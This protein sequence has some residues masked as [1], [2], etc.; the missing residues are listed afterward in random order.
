MFFEKN[1][2]MFSF[3]KKKKK[4]VIT[5]DCKTDKILINNKEI[6][7]PTNHQDL[8]SILGE[9]T[10]IT[11]NTDKTYIFW[12]DLGIFCGYVNPEKII[13]ISFLQKIKSVTNY[14]PKKPF[15]GNLFFNNEDITNEEFIKI[16]FGKY[17][18]HRLGPEREIRYGF[19]ISANKKI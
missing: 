7:L 8:I 13:S 9:P 11:K 14:K 18:I 1:T 5:I 10:R 3:L 19:T 17:V 15:S 4:Q 16:S 12:D 2:F 6:I